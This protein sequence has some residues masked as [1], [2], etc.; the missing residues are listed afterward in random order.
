[1]EF[2]KY[3]DVPSDSFTKDM[4]MNQEINIEEG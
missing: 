3:L 1:M 2:T 4:E